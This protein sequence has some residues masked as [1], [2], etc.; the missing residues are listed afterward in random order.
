MGY[1]THGYQYHSIRSAVIISGTGV[2]SYH[3]HVY[4]S[5]FVGALA[6]YRCDLVVVHLAVDVA[7]S[8][9]KSAE[10]NGKE[11]KYYYNEVSEQMA[12]FLRGFYVYVFFF[13]FAPLS[14]R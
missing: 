7:Y 11:Q 4:Y 10:N 13:T 5:A 6:F 3:K 8:G 12:L 9:I 14:V 2:I 1:G